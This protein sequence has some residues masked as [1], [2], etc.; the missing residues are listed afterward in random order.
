MQTW[1]KCNTYTCVFRLHK[2]FCHHSWVWLSQNH[3]YIYMAVD[4]KHVSEMTAVYYLAYLAVA[5]YWSTGWR[6]TFLQCTTA[7]IGLPLLLVHL[8]YAVYVCLRRFCVYRI[9]AVNKD[10]KWGSSVCGYSSLFYQRLTRSFQWIARTL[11]RLVHALL[12]ALTFQQDFLIEES[13][14]YHSCSFQVIGCDSE[15]RCVWCHWLKLVMNWRLYSHITR[16]HCF[17]WICCEW[18]RWVEFCTGKAD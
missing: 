7:K 14:L 18:V 13:D 5:Q 16:M 4:E 8:F 6:T 10:Y 15:D 11:L 3:K 9:I 12:I 17:L 2:L 1:N